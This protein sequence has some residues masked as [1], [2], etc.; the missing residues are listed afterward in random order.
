MPGSWLQ[1]PA[2]PMTGCVTWAG[3]SNPLL[4]II[5]QLGGRCSNWP[6]GLLRG[7]GGRPQW[8]CEWA[9]L[10]PSSLVILWRLLLLPPL[11]SCFSA[12]P[13]LSPLLQARSYGRVFAPAVSSSMPCPFPQLQKGPWSPL[14]FPINSPDW[15]LNKNRF[16]SAPK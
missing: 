13:S 4:C 11:A 6:C 10:S 15:C 9:A 5:Y 16:F 8:V 7:L 3:P 1:T 12:M 14:G 2:L